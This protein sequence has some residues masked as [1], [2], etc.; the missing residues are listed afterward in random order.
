ML[1]RGELQTFTL[2]R[3]RMVSVDSL[4]KLIARRERA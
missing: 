3:R 1:E 2:G 4:R